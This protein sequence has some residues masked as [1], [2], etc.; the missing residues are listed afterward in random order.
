ML[1]RPSHDYFHP[2]CVELQLGPYNLT[3]ISL[4]ID[5][6]CEDICIFKFHPDADLWRRSGV[7]IPALSHGNERS[8]C[9]G[10]Q[11]RIRQPTVSHSAKSGYLQCHTAWSQVTRSVI[12]R[13]VRLL[14]VSHSAKL[15][16]LQCHTAMQGVRLPWESGYLQCHTMRSQAAWGDRLPA[17]SQSAESGYPGKQATRSVTQGGVR[18]PGESGF[19]QCHTAWSQATHSVIQRRVRLP[20]VSQSMESGYS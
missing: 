1:K 13:E 12:Q 14:S 9:N 16:Y 6:V 8:T 4:P 3:E 15:G 17:V 10:T 18:L 2:F 20:T 19:V 11:C 5:F 7:R